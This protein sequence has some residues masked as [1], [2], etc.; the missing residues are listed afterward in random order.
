MTQPTSEDTLCGQPASCEWQQGH[1]L[2]KDSVQGNRCRAGSDFFR[3]YVVTVLSQLAFACCRWVRS[4]L[5]LAPFSGS[6]RCQVFACCRCVQEGECVPT[7]CHSPQESTRV[8]QN[9]VKLK[10]KVCRQ[11]AKK[12][13]TLAVPCVGIVDWCEHSPALC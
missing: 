10:I 6:I 4:M 2:Y 13:C 11:S 3:K 5:A 12:R 7:A 8:L 1:F 9:F